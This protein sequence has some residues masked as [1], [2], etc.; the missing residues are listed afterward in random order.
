MAAASLGVTVPTI[1]GMVREL[2]ESW[3][4]AGVDVI[5]VEGAGGVASP[6]AADGDTADLAR[7]LDADLALLVADAGLGVINACRLSVNHLA[8]LPT[9]VHLNRYNAG[10][11]LHRANAGWL[12]ERDGFTVTTEIP[13]LAALLLALSTNRPGQ[14][15]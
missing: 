6:L 8:P 15:E 11:G 10:S 9:V 14:R 12:A 13:H 4:A 2:D 7:A 3:P 1:K 5:L